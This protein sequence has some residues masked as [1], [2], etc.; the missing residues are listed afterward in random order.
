MRRKWICWM[1]W[2]HPSEVEHTVGDQ[3]LMLCSECWTT[4]SDADVSKCT[5]ASRQHGNSFQLENMG[6]KP[7]QMIILRY[8]YVFN[9][10]LWLWMHI[11][12]WWC[13]IQRLI[14]LLQNVAPVTHPYSTFG[15]AHAAY[16]THTCWN[17]TETHTHL[18]TQA[19]AYTVPARLDARRERGNECSSSERAF[20][21]VQIVAMVSRRCHGNTSCQ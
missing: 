17:A 18:Y 2:D 16:L 20:G 7:T 6:H 11:S 9:S 8:E 10:V 12:T 19:Y 21:S 3:R 4:A 5:R 13:A 1:T 14:Q 15:C